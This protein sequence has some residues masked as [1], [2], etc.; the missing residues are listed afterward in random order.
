MYEY[1]PPHYEGKTPY[2]L[3]LIELEEGVRVLSHIVNC[4]PEDIKIG[5]DVEVTFEKLTDEIF[6]PKFKLVKQVQ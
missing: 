3:A 4:K 5:M 2:I 1:P 6:L